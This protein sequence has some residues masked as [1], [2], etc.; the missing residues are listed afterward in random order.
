[1]A[2]KAT[3]TAAV[4]APPAILTRDRADAMK[5]RFRQLVREW[6][7][8][9]P[10]AHVATERV[11]AAV[12]KDADLYGFLANPLVKTACFEAV[13]NAM[14]ARR[15]VV[16]A[17]PQPSAVEARERVTA[18]GHSLLDS[19]RL[20][21]GKLLGDATSGELAEAAVFYDRQARDMSWKARFLASVAANV[22]EGQRVRAVLTEAELRKMQE[23]ASDV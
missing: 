5:E 2:T 10:N 6:A 21:N 9:A 14:R 15:R 23:G 11:F 16:W 22:P 7:E 8:T 13:G 17:M 19:F 20:P 18:L 1:M 12:A 4:S 3:A